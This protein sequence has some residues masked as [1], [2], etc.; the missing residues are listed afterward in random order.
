MLDVLGLVERLGGLA[1]ATFSQLELHSR[2]AKIEWA[3]EKSRLQ[4]MCV[5]ILVAVIL[6]LCFL[7]L[8]STLTILLV[9]NTEYRLGIIAGLCACYAL[10]FLICLY[11]FIKLSAQS[12]KRFA[13]TRQEIAADIALI[14]RYL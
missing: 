1:K 9:W 4:R 10:G 3:E 14:E 2:L 12:S 13:A 11:G 8:A 7:L 5:F 6:L